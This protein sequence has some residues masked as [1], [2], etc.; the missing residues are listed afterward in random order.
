MENLEETIHAYEYYIDAVKR[1]GVPYELIGKIIPSIESEVNNI[2]S[3]I[4]DFTV[5][6]E[7]DGKNINGRI[8]YSDD[9]Q[10]SLELSSGMERFISSL[11]IRVALITVSN[12]PKPNFLIIDEGLGTLSIDNLMSM[13]MLFSILRNQFDFLVIISHLEAVR[14]MVDSLMEIRMDN[15]YSQINY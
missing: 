7:L 9:R 8:C 10:W 3:Q 2:L 14:D 6:L 5:A 12:L 1:D 15:G 13:H 11:A 4:T